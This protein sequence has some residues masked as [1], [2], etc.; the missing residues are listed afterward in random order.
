MKYERDQ[1]VSSCWYFT[2][3]ASQLFLST[4]FLD[5]DDEEQEDAYDS[6]DEHDG[7]DMD[8]LVLTNVIFLMLLLSSSFRTTSWAN[9][10]FSHCS[11]VYTTLKKR[12]LTI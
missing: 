10:V 6:D 12:C 4:S 9:N 5:F 2:I 11:N 7:D 1:F 8:Y 3:T